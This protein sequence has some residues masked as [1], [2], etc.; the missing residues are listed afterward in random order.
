VEDGNSSFATDLIKKMLPEERASYSQMFYW[1]MRHLEPTQ[2]YAWAKLNIAG[3][4]TV[5]EVFTNKTGVRCKRFTETLKVHE[6]KQ[7]LNGLAC[8]QKNGA[9]CKLHRNA[10]PACGLGQEPSGWRDFKR[11]VGN[12]F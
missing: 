6:I 4:F 7:T 5:T 12:M 9:W 1:S 11:S 2:H 8:E 10:T 3:E